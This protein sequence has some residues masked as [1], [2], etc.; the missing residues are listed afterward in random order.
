M[1]KRRI[2]LSLEAKSLRRARL[3]AEAAEQLALVPRR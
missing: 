2:D 1:R 3:R